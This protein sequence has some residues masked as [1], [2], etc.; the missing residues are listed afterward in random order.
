MLLHIKFFLVFVLIAVNGI[1]QSITDPIRN[2]VLFYQIDKSEAINNRKTLITDLMEI[3]YR[4]AVGSTD[5]ILYSTFTE[6]SRVTIP[7][8]HPNFSPIFLQL[9]KDDKA[10]IIVSTDS[11]YKYTM[12]TP[13]PPYLH[14][15][16]SIHFYFKIYN[17]MNE[18]E[19]SQHEYTKA[20]HAREHDNEALE[21]YIKA[22]NRLQKT[23]KGVYYL[24]LN[25]GTGDKITNGKLVTVKYKAYLFDG[26]VF[27]NNTQ[28]YTFRM[29]SK[30]VI[31]GWED[32]IKEM[33][34]GSRYKLIIPEKLAF[35]S[36]GTD[37]VPPY[38]SVVFEV[39]VIKVE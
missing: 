17:V 11:F 31:E 1:A 33:R 38:T 4:M 26:K 8:E 37:I 3:D 39:E 25:P 36:Q 23:E 18:K 28:G 12:L 19:F 5:S 35:G 24:V 10:T 34:L 13:I 16:D 9:Q 21:K 27:E 14:E 15:G 20:Q 7:V 2:G 29:G 30:E 22:Y 32:G 6:G